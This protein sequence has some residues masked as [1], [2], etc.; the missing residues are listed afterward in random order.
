MQ[1]FLLALF[2]F[3]L[4]AAF[5]TLAIRGWRRRA[6]L[7]SLGFTPPLESLNSDSEPL[8]SIRAHYVATTVFSEPLNR[9]SAYGLGVRGKAA[10]SIF[11]TGIEIDRKGERA[12]AIATSSID[13]IGLAQATIDRVVEPN[14]LFQINWSQQ[15]SHF[16]TFLRVT[17]SA[18]R[19]KMQTK[20]ELLEIGHPSK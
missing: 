17:N 9:I 20:L 18:E 4:F 6:S 13:S 2:F 1:K 7:Q 12:L 19:L 10:V 14:G 3:A 8:T 5:A 15:D 11:T 16:S